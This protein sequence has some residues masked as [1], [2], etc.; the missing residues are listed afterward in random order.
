MPLI[1]HFNKQDFYFQLKSNDAATA[2]DRIHD[3]IFPLGRKHV[4]YKSNTVHME[5]LGVLIVKSLMKAVPKQDMDPEK[6]EEI[7][8]AFYV[9]FKVIVYWLQFGFRYEKRSMT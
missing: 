6:Y 2:D 5:I 3:I 1:E 7:N 9:F 4:G 8:K